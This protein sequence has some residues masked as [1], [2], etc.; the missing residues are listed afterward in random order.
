MLKTWFFETV[1]KAEKEDATILR[2]YECHN[3]RSKVAVKAAVP[4]TTVY[5]CD[6]MER[7]ISEVPSKDGEFSFEIKPFEI[8]T[9]KLL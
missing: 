6:L 8:R 3:K 7:N 4:F 1:K 5:E 2:L 9:F